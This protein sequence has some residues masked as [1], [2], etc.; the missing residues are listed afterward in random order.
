MPAGHGDHGGVVHGVTQGGYVSLKVGGPGAFLPEGSQAGIC[1]DTA[2][3]GYTGHP[4]LPGISYRLLRQIPK[5][6]LL[7]GGTQVF[8]G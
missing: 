1:S 8:Y 5:N 6:P 4:R 2:Y 7:P 3:E